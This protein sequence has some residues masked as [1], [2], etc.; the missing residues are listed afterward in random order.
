MS[1]L[2]ADT[3][4][5]RQCADALKRIHNEFTTHGNPADEY[6]ADE[7]GSSLITGAFDEF[8]SNWKIHREQ[9]AKE[10]ETL[11]KI[12]EDAAKTYDAVDTDLANAL[13]RQD[14]ARQGPN[15][16]THR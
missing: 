2:K 9:L 3:E 16:V 5:I 13:R 14:K 7:L 10:L 15:G 1:D 8:G 11:G 4:R 6:T 12:T